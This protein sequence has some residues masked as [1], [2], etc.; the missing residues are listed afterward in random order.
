M[1]WTRWPLKGLFNPNYFVILSCVQINHLMNVYTWKRR[2]NPGNERAIVPRYSAGTK[3]WLLSLVKKR[4]LLK[5]RSTIKFL[6]WERYVSRSRGEV[7]MLLDRAKGLISEHGFSPEGELGE[8]LLQLWL[9]E[10][11]FLE[12]LLWFHCPLLSCSHIHPWRLS[13]SVTLISCT[14][15]ISRKV[16]LGQALLFEV[17]KFSVTRY[18]FSVE[19]AVLVLTKPM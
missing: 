10:G 6:I 5:I 18:C 4:M 9:L 11:E 16:G 3:K 8:V 17:V 13:V 2:E 15:V 12:S 7:I 19:E 14:L 1:D